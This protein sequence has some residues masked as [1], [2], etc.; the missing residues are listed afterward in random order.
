MAPFA[1]VPLEG[2][3]LNVVALRNESFA[4]WQLWG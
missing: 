1:Q 4:V 3:E 2:V